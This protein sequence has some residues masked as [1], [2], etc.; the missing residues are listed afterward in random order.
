[1]A[2]QVQPIVT[3][4]TDF[5]AADP[6]VAAMKGTL[7]CAYPTATL[8]DISHE[9]PAHDVVAG[10]FVLAAAAPCFPRGTLHL[11]VVDPGV[12]TDREILV[13]QFGGQLF[14]FPDNG[15]I[16]LI[17]EAMPLEGLVA[18]RNAPP[19]T[20]GPI[21]STFHGRDLFAPLAGQIL[22]GANV[23]ELGPTPAK[24]RLLDLPAAERT[25]D[26]LLGQV[27]YVDHFGNLITNLLEAD[28]RRRWADLRD[29]ELL[30]GDE[31]V[32]AFANT[33]GL[34]EK[35]KT[36]ALFNSSG[37]VEIAVNQGRA[38][39]ALSA[40]VGTEVRL[41]DKKILDA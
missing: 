26:G 30:C 3:L 18:V 7:L 39:D 10:A 4:L 8:V 32:G 16:T 1:M 22:R 24:Y 20:F 36:L 14:L 13:G 34:A 40:C 28:V 17:K 25:T 2:R 27:I 21:S 31:R 35:G 6:Y 41:R 5:G 9:V 19:G 23:A 29:T 37:R 33:Y 12:G 38:C 15:V 11:V